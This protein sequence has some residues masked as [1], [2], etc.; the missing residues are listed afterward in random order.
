MGRGIRAMTVFV[1]MVAAAAI[2]TLARAQDAH[3]SQAAL[4]MPRAEETTV[5]APTSHPEKKQKPTHKAAAKTTK[6]KTDTAMVPRSTFEDRTAHS[7]DPLS[8]TLAPD[9]RLDPANDQYNQATGQFQTSDSQLVAR[10]PDDSV[11]AGASSASIENMG[12]GHNV[13]VV[14]PLFQILNS[15]SPGPASQ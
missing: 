6:P 3:L 9:T 11:N 4:T 2:P 5:T 10:T 1:A 8:L 12:L 13:T 14:V 15:I 7:F